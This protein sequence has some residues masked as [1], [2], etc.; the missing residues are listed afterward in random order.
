MDKGLIKAFLLTIAILATLYQYSD[1]STWNNMWFIGL[2][3][4]G[5]WVGV[6]RSSRSRRLKKIKNVVDLD[7]YRSRKKRK[8]A[9][10]AKPVPSPESHH[11]TILISSPDRGQVDLISALL[12]SN[13]IECFVSNRHI[14][15]ILPSIEG[16][17]LDI[18]IFT[19]DLEVAQKIL[20]AHGH[21]INGD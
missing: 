1:R 4:G 11:K 15:S 7:L 18:L 9:S 10:K 17:N 13:H 8:K 3:F 6:S 21:Q 20:K 2:I 5:C 16:I 14:S 19:E 12:T